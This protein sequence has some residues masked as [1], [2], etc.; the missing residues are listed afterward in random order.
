MDVVVVVVVKFYFTREVSSAVP[1]LP[2][3]PEKTVVQTKR[4]NMIYVKIK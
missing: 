4:I 1:G 2:E 3:S